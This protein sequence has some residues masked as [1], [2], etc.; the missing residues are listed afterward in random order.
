MQKGKGLYFFLLAGMLL[1]SLCIAGILVCSACRYSYYP[2]T[3]YNASDVLFED[4]VPMHVLTVVLAGILVWCLNMVFDKKMSFKWQERIC[5]ITLGI[6]ALV[7]F[8]TGTVFVRANPY[9]PLGDQLNTTAGAYYFQNGDFSMLM[10]GGYIGLY[11]QQKG[12]AFLYEILFA[13]FEPFCYDVAQQFHVFF[14]VIAL[15]AGYGFVKNHFEKA[16]YRMVFCLMMLLCAP[17]MIFLPYIYGDIPSICFCMV[18]FWALSAYEKCLQKRYVVIAAVAAA[19]ALM[20]RMN[21]WIVLIAVLIG[22]VVVAVERWDYKPLLAGLCVILAASGAIKAIDVMYEYR[23]GYE[24]GIGIPSI[25]WVAMGLQETDGEAGVYNRYQQT[26]FGETGFDREL[27]A[28]IGK[29]YISHRIAEFQDNPEMAQ[30]FFRK[31]MQ[32][33]WIEPLFESLAATNSFK[34]EEPI[35]QWIMDL[36]YGSLHDMVWKLSNYYQ[37]IVYAAMLL[38][39]IGRMVHLR[40]RDAC[41]TL[42]IPQIAIVGGFLFSLIWENQSRYCLPYY[43]FMLLYVPNGLMQ[44]GNAIGVIGRKISAGKQSGKDGKDKQQLKKVS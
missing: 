11:Q 16:I 20:C 34:T 17:L 26:V 41:N 10:P 38:G 19:L 36:Y 7:L 37:S 23:S 31:K 22:M 44:I 25:L 6:T 18:L 24:S 14:I 27:S 42:W 35:A 1:S 33:Q 28:Q 8:I 12:F 15:F 3:D 29:D 4:S 40:E 32:T 21:T 13:M 5:R 43:V 30:E 9:Y 39:I 2:L